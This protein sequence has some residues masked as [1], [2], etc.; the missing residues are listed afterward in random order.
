[1]KQRGMQATYYHDSPY[2]VSLY[3]GYLL[4]SLLLITV[5]SVIPSVTT[6][7]TVTDKDIAQPVRVRGDQVVGIRPK[8]HVAAVGA[9]RAGRATFVPLLTRRTDADTRGLAGLAVTDKGIGLIIR[10]PGDQVVGIRIKRHVAPVGADRGG[11]ATFIPLRTLRTDAD[12]RG[13]AGLAI[14]DKS[15]VRTVRVTGDQI[16]G[17]RRKR[18]VTP[19]GADCRGIA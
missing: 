6:I 18:H 15:I 8:R 13:L 7:S 4:R 2:S 12:A 5:I 11:I 3:T 16:V 17:I 1:M 10:V 9:D 19:V 14:V